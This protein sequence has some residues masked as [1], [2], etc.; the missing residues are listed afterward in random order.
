MAVGLY[1]RLWQGVTCSAVV[2]LL[3]VVAVI[4]IMFGK[5]VKIRVY[6]LHGSGRLSRV[7]IYIMVC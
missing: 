3:A 6:D 5:L 4:F 7:T 1:G 2:F